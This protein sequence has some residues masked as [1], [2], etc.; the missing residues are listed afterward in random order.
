MATPAQR[1]RPRASAVS[2]AATLESTT[3]DMA[4]IEIIALLSNP[5]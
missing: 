1:S 5:A 3:T 4:I 2:A